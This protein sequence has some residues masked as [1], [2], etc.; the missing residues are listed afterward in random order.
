MSPW[1]TVRKLCAEMKAYNFC[2]H[3]ITREGLEKL[4]VAHIAY[5]R[6]ALGR[7]VTYLATS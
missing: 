1:S 6:L 2:G 5:S 7:V 3:T 4:A